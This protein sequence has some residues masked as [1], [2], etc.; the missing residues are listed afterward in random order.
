MSMRALLL[1]LLMAPTGAALA[2]AA[3]QIGVT[4][5]RGAAWNDAQGIRHEGLDGRGVAVFMDE[6]YDGTHPALDHCVDPDRFAATLSI[7]PAPPQPRFLAVVPFDYD[8]E[9]AV[10]SVARGLG[11]QLAEY[12]SRSDG[13]YVVSAAAVR[14]RTDDDDEGASPATTNSAPRFLSE[15]GTQDIC[16]RGAPQRCTRGCAAARSWASRFFCFLRQS[17]AGKG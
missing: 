3:D 5:I 2:D 9:Q 6:G 10:G 12:L 1:L 4:A 7:A 17:R 15:R 16:G 11:R 14:Q 8:G 13:L